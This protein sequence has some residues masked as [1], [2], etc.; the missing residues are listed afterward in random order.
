MKV[1]VTRIIPEVGLR[2]M[3]DAGLEVVQWEEKRNMTSQE[4]IDACKSVN[5]LL[6]AGGKIDAHFL[7]ECKHLKVIALHSV[8]F[9]R[10]DVAEATRL[11]IP[12]GNT[13]GVL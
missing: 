7:N 11:K 6:S 13:P 2:R 5:A 8:G 1:F 10:V 3:V 4:L 9:D 12:V